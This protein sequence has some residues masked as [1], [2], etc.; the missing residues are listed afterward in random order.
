MGE[1]P[2]I[3]STKLPE[4]VILPPVPQRM[5]LPVP[6]APIP[7]YQPLVLP[8]AEQIR[9]MRAAEED[10]EKEKDS[11][12]PAQ[13]YQQQNPIQVPL[14][15]INIPEE[16]PQAQETTKVTLPGTSIKLTVPKEEVLTTAA[17]TAGV[18]ALASVAAT[19]AAGPL[20]QR[21]TK[22]LKPVMKTALKKLA[23]VKAVQSMNLSESDAKLR[24]RRRARKRHTKDGQV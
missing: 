7:S 16:T 23:A 17:A 4:P 13:K 19:M 1:P 24:W 6:S 11:E 14:P 15:A 5:T 12:R 18:A 3:P 22:I 20:V 2:I 9:Q 8:S 21:L 10:V